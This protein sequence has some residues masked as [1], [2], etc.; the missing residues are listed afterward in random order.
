MAKVSL[1]GSE[2]SIEEIWSWYNDQKEALRDFKNKIIVSLQIVPS[3]VDDKFITMT[4]E[5]VNSYFASSVEE[6]EHLVALDLISATEGNLRADFYSKVY[7]KDKSDLARKFRTLYKLKENKISLEEDIIENWKIYS[8][9][10]SH[11]SE[12]IGLLKY[13]HWLAHGRY[14]NLTKK[15]RTYTAEEA[16]E[17]AENIFVQL[18]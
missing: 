2:K 4:L 7:N 12:F 16:Y 5:E 10:K 1:S 13:R 17:I 6:L 8:E 14:W 18:I 9:S 15:G 3:H 11:F